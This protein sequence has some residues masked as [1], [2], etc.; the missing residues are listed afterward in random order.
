MKKSEAAKIGAKWWTDQIRESPPQN[1]GGFTVSTLAEWSKVVVGKLALLTE[2][3]L[4]VFQSRLET[5][6]LNLLD[7]SDWLEDDPMQGFGSRII[8]VDYDPS[9]ELLDAIE[10]ANISDLL[11][12]LKTM[13]WLDPDS[14]KVSLGYG[15][16][17]TDVK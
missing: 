10:A 7:K 3:K 2:Q 15:G 13:M 11:L 9:K 1:V 16:K 4:S 12:P 17:I 14:V 5:N 6:L 8:E